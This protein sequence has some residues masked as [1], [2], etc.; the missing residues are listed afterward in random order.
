MR[1]IHRN[2]GT[3]YDQ[4]RKFVA[5]QIYDPVFDKDEEEIVMMENKVAKIFIE[6]KNLAE[7]LKLNIKN[8]N[9]LE[10]WKEMVLKQNIGVNF[11]EIASFVKN[12]HGN[13]LTALLGKQKNLIDLIS[14]IEILSPKM[15]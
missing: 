11:E 1:W 8:K 9:I 13:E 14:S 15:I 3:F 7:N 2:F 10:K 4:I 6:T 12:L 5:E